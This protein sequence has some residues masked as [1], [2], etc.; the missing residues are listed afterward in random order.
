ME[1]GVWVRWFFS[2]G[3][4]C[5]GLLFFGVGS[6]YSDW[7]ILRVVTIW[8]PVNFC[9]A[10]SSGWGKEVQLVTCKKAFKIA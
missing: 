5:I 10:V 2:F 1:E 7:F 4:R 9:R 8:C 3:W 6:V